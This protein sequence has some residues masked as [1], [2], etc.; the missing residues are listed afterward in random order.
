[1]AINPYESPEIPRERGS[2]NIIQLLVIAIGVV[3]ATIVLCVVALGNAVGGFT[4]ITSESNL[5]FCIMVG[6]VFGSPGAA[7]ASLFYS[8][9][10]FRNPIVSLLFAVVWPIIVSVCFYFFVVMYMLG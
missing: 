2:S 6:L 1:M 5:L 8:V 9:V 10:E 3:V 4:F 7:I